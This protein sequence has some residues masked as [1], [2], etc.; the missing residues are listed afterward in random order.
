MDRSFKRDELYEL[1]WSEPIKTLAVRYGVSD[2]A[3]AKT[4]RRHAIPVPPR[5]YW[6]KIQAGKK[7]FTQPLSPRGIGMPEVIRTGHTNDWSRYV[8]PK[9][10]IET[11]IPPPPEFPDSVLDLTERVR[12]LVGKVGIPRNLA[13][14]HR[15]IAMLLEEDEVRRQKHLASRYRSS[16][17]APLFDSPFERRRL[18]LLNAIFTA[19]ERSGMKPSLRGKDPKDFEVRVG[20]EHVSFTLDHPGQERYG[21]G[22]ASQRNRPA[23][24]KLHLRISHGRTLDD[25][26][27]LWEDKAGEP[28]EKHIEDIVVMLIVA[29]EV[30]YRQGEISHRNWLI[31]R[32]AQ[33]IE[34]AQKRKGEE[35]RRERERRLKAEQARVHRLL[36]EATAFRQAN[37]IRAYVETTR[38][39]NAA[40]ADPVSREELDAWA[41]W[42]LAQADRIDPV[43]SKK[44]LVGYADGT[45]KFVGQED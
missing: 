34:E 35:E 5:G 16:W 42:A 8:E 43:R 36:S 1:V 21:Y 41:S 40:S 18:R 15:H 20:D 2:V 17:D 22:P 45:D 3:L 31:E 13:K 29:G 9:S 14:A 37:D 32:K 27:F 4:C 25:V 10:L 30:Q 33:L 19:L 6:A 23:S 7:A 38:K 39:A 24:D 44:F 12:K 26:R 11:E 28:I